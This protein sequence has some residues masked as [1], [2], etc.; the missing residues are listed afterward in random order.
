MKLNYD[1]RDSY[2]TAC[3]A[4]ATLV[5]FV[6]LLAFFV[7]QVKL[8]VCRYYL[9]GKSETGLQDSSVSTVT[10]FDNELL[11]AG[12]DLGTQEE[13]DYFTVSIGLN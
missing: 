1:G 6:C 10:T 12:Y 5:V 9:L 11:S 7:L 4:V 2:G 13:T 8:I 3:G